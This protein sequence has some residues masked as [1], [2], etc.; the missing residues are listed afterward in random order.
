MSAKE[1]SRVILQK[2]INSQYLEKTGC[3]FIYLFF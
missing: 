3:G 2:D 1:D